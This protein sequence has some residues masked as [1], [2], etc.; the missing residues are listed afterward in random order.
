M[1]PPKKGGSMMN[2]KSFMTNPDNEYNCPECPENN[3]P[4][5]PCTRDDFDRHLPCGQQNCWV[6]CTV[7]R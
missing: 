6:T 2:E 5:S 1:T 7:N 4:G 3:E